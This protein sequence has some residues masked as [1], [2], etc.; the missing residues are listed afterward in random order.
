MA[1]CSAISGVSSWHATSGHAAA[2]RFSSW[3]LRLA[4]GAYGLWTLGLA[5]GVYRRKQWAWRQGLAFFGAAGL[6]SVLQAFMSPNFLH[7]AA[8]RVILCV[9]SLAVTLYWGWWWYA[10]RVHFSSD[11]DPL[12]QKQPW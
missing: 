7:D 11:A 12:S 3:L 6:T 9:L 10:Q 4:I 1:V 2:T 8:F 5:F